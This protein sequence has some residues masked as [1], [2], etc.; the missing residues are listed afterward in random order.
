MT[1]TLRKHLCIKLDGR[2]LGPILTIQ[3]AIFEF[4]RLSEAEQ[5]RA[6]IHYDGKVYVLSSLPDLRR[7]ES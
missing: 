2:L 5:D 7:A 4:E 6:E 3:E 1:K